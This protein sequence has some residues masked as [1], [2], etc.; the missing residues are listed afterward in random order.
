[1]W[2]AGTELSG[3][4]LSCRNSVSWMSCFRDLRSLGQD[5]FSLPCMT[6]PIDFSPVLDFHHRAGREQISAEDPPDAVVRRNAG[7]GLRT[8]SGAGKRLRIQSRVEGPVHVQVA[9]TGIPASVPQSSC[10]RAS[11][12]NGFPMVASTQFHKTDSVRNSVISIV[13]RIILIRIGNHCQPQIASLGATCFNPWCRSTMRFGGFTTV[14]F[15]CA[16]L[17]AVSSCWRLCHERKP[18]S[19]LAPHSGEAWLPVSR[20]QRARGGT[21]GNRPSARFLRH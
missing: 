16:R 20:A 2:R 7:C 14:S 3:T 17:R 6:Q 10:T 19:P 13:M 12:G 4:A 1:M 18:A 5:E 9:E 11:S 15:R 8:R 21:M